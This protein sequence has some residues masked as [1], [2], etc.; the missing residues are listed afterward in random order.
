MLCTSLRIIFYRSPK[1]GGP[2]S[3]RPAFAE[4]TIS[5][6]QAALHKY[7]LLIHELQVNIQLHID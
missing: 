2:G 7:Q 4:G 1:R 3:T 6:V 5:A